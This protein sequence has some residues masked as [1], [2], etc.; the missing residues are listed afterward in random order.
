MRS[1]SCVPVREGPTDDWF[2]PILLR[3]ALEILVIENFPACREVQDIRSLTR[4]GNQHPDSVIKAL[5]AERGT[6]DV[7]LYHHD[8]APA[9]KSDEV[10]RRMREAWEA[11]GTPEPMVTVVPIR[12]TEAW[13]LAD[14][15]AL[16]T[17]LC[18]RR[19]K[20]DIP[21]GEGVERCA[22]PKALLAALLK[23]DAGMNP[24]K[25]GVMRD[26]YINMAEAADIAVLKKV[27]SFRQWWA[28]MIKAL[29]GLGYQHG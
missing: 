29:E 19:P 24:G 7:V 3:R 11:I 18:L 20:T 5:E 23:N 12:E 10:I 16:S 17:V 13:I 22:D 27:P 1:V 26:F 15:A 6:Y 4:A 2:L 25:T 21:V 28:D 14:V 8:G 9:S